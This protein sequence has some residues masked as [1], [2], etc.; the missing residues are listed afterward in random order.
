MSLHDHIDV[1]ADGLVTRARTL[2][3]IEATAD[4]VD[5]DPFI[6]DTDTLTLEV[7][8]GCR[9]RIGVSA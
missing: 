1:G 5:S 4:G 8:Q 9:G 6:H 7:G 2:K 3:V